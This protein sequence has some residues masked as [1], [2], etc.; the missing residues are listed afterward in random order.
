VGKAFEIVTGRVTNAGSTIT[1][2]TNATG[3][4]NTVRS[5]DISTSQAHLEQAW[6]LGATAGVVRVRSPRLH[7]VS[8]GVRM[9]YAVTDPRPLLTSYADEGLYAQDTLIIEQSGGGAETDCES[10]LI[11]YDDLPGV[12]AR[13]AML[14]DIAPR[15]AHIMTVEVDLTTGGTAGDYGGSAAINSNFDVLKANTDYAIL[16]YTTSASVL[17]VGIKSADFGNLRVG[18]PGHIQRDET[19]NWFPWLTEKTG[20]P[21]I[22][23]FN[24]ANKANTL[25]DLVHTAT[26]TGITVTLELAQLT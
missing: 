16:G 4:S 26:S 24:A 15:I 18:G 9:N 17:S 19:R 20:R 1:A 10:V 3:D 11:Y 13:L 23:V 14:G 21:H 2:V 5:F 25:V 6:A 7:D 22:P 8:Q 12:N